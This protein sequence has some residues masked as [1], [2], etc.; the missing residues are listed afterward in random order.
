MLSA[1]SAEGLKLRRH[2]ATWLLV[3]IFPIGVFVITAIALLAE[4]AT[5]KLPAPGAPELDVWIRGTASFWGAS[6][7]GL[8]RMLVCAFVA[9]VF[10]GE[11]GW[12]TWKLIVP[13]RSRTTLIAA[14]YLVILAFVYAAF[15]MAGLIFMAMGVLEDVVTGDPLPAGITFGALALAQVQG[16]IANLPAMLVAIAFASLISILTRSTTAAIVISVIYVTLE[17]LFFAFAPALSLYLPGVVELLYQL[18]P[19]YHVQNLVS[20]LIEGDAQAVPFASGE[21]AYGW[22]LSLAIVGAWITSMVGLTFFFFRR[23]DIN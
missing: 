4:L 21:I 9:V 17:Q 2:R 7:G 3:W 20:W 23:Q 13:H 11:Y 15:V 8:F 14:N 16:L 12:N 22:P 19:V 5:G 6:R 18:L 10:A 1:M